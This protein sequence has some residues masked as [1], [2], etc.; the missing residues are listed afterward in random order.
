M[1]DMPG[2]IPKQ[3]KIAMLEGK[4]PYKCKSKAYK[5]MLQMRERATLKRQGV[6]DMGREVSEGFDVTDPDDDAPD[7]EVVG[8]YERHGC[9]WEPLPV[10][11]KVS[12]TVE[13]AQK[14]MRM[15]GTLCLVKDG[16]AYVDTSIG[17]VVGPAESVEVEE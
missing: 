9:R 6:V 14:K 11:T 5:K 3:A 2:D 10:G 15:V 12:L 1:H 16:E 17:T 8:A 13:F 4:D 7:G